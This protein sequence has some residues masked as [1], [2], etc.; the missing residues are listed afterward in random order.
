M[1]ASFG[2]SRTPVREALIRLADE[3]LIDIYPQAGT[4]VSRIDL[5]A[6]R[7]AQFVRQALETAVAIEAASTRVRCQP[8]SNRSSSARSVPSA[9]RTSRHSS[10]RTR[11]STARS[12]RW[13]AMARR[14]ASSK[15]PSRTSTASV[16]SRSHR[17]RRCVEM[18]RQHRAI[19][20]AIR[21]GDVAAAVDAVRE[22]STVILTIAPAI[23]AR[24]PDLFPVLR[25]P[26]RWTRPDAS[27]ATRALT[28]ATV[29]WLKSPG[30]PCLR[31]D[32]AV[33]KSTTACSSQ[34][35]S[36]P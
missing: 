16:S 19:A 22:H 33:A 31:H 8:C 12:S 10:R 29:T 15:P 30:I 26:Q 4:F 7:E 20:G 9:T 28:S 17:R 34:P 11:I 35:F 5:A 2:V 36:R 27:P 14:G 25:R 32:A 1:A 24:H 21:D 18:L 6:V 3:G 23:A 13:A